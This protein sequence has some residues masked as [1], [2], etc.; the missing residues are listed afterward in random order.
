MA[1]ASANRAGLYRVKETTWGV[2]PATPALIQTR[3]TGEALDDSISTE[4]SQEIRDDRMT[5]DLIL[6]DSSP[7]G[8][9]NFEMSYGTYDDLL[10]AAL[11][12]TDWSDALVIV[13]VGGD[14]STVAVA[15]DNIT[16]STAGKFTDVVVGQWILL[17]GFTNPALNRAYHVTAKADNQTLTVEPQPIAAETPALGAASVSGEYIRNGVTEHSFTFV[18]Q[19]N[20]ATV[21]TRHI[22]DGIRI[23]GFTLEMQT[24]SILTGTFNVIGKS[25]EMSETTF[26]GESIVAASTTEVMNAVTN[27]INIHQNGAT[28]GSPGSINSLSLELDNQHREQKGIGELGNVGVVGGT[29]VINMTASMYFESKDQADMFKNGEAFAF[30]F[31]LQDNSGNTYIFTLPRC[32]YESFTTNSSQLDSDVMA[33]VQFTALRDPV[34]NC[35]I[36]IDRFTAP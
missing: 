7:S 20:D 35:M 2:T 22:F 36:Q 18:K 6:T 5:T 4:K 10:L 15:V 27:V 29:L 33:E 24:A 26:A 14:I 16:S 12:T 13:G 23:G 9:F 3:Y 32:K 11:M 8:S 25:A 19:F 34:T 21:V 1:F 31:A 30:S 28:I 17:G